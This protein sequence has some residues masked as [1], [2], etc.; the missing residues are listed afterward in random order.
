MFRYID[1]TGKIVNSAQKLDLRLRENTG[2]RR[3]NRPR[4]IG[5]DG[6]ICDMT[7]DM[8]LRKRGNDFKRIP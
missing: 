1:R 2:L 7:R 8:D 5:P 3:Y 4:F 6:S